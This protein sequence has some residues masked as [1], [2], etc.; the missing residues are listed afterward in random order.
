MNGWPTI[1]CP[2]RHTMEPAGAYA[3][4]LAADFGLPSAATFCRDFGINFHKLCLGDADAMARFAHLT[5]SDLDSMKLVSPIFLGEGRFQIGTEVL[6][7]QHS[8]QTSLY[9]CPECVAEDIALAGGKAPDAAV[10]WRRDWL[11]SCL[12]TCPRHGQAHVFFRQ[13]SPSNQ[14]DVNLAAFGIEDNLGELRARTPI[15]EVTDFQ[16]YI[17]GRLDGV[18]A[19]IP[20][21]AGLPLWAVV[22][23]CLAVGLTVL[24]LSEEWN[25]RLNDAEAHDAYQ[26]G[27]AVLAAGRE[28]LKKLYEWRLSI[29]GDTLDSN[30]G[31]KTLLGMVAYQRLIYAFK[32]E[33][34]AE[35]KREFALAFYEVAPFYPGRDPMFGVPPPEM[36]NWYTIEQAQDRYGIV[37]AS[38]LSYAKSAGLLRQVSARKILVDARKADEFFLNSGGMLYLQ[39]LGQEF[40]VSEAARKAFVDGGLLIPLTERTGKARQ[41]ARFRRTDVRELMRRLLAH[42]Q[43]V[44][45]VP[46]GKEPLMAAMKKIRLAFVQLHQLLIDGTISV[47][48]LEGPVPPYQSILVDVTEVQQVLSGMEKARTSEFTADEAAREIGISRVLLDRLLA[49]GWIDGGVRRN[50]LTGQPRLT[51]DAD[52]IQEFKQTY[53][54]LYRIGRKLRRNFVEVRKSLEDRG[55]GPA[56]PQHTLKTWI[57]RR[58]DIP[59]DLS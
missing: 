59:P 4:R 6:R 18:A 39:D 49:N 36:P 12:D 19:V 57:Y 43:P 37:R 15:R 45:E 47:W 52:V 53:V 17:T 7:N 29:V 16:R 51:F 20:M 28:G 10:W 22:L 8:R 1:D 24:S 40:G 3:S 21:L 27:F 33:A 9:V 54:T 5:N 25:R 31:L 14:W 55:I 38:L 34:L 46:P 56:F 42:A 44:K 26:A 30:F 2:P 32:N 58:A 11:V 13:A 35:L 41:R 48:Q 50:A 23:T